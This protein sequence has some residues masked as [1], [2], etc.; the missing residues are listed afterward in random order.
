MT[1]DYKFP[2]QLRE[3]IVNALPEDT[4][5]HGNEPELRFTYLPATHAKALRPESMLVVG[6]RGSGKSF[7]WSALQKPEHRETVGKDIGLNRNTKVST[8]FGERPQPD[9]YPGKD[10]LTRLLVEFEARSI[11]RT[12]VLKQIGGGRLPEEFNSLNRWKDRIGWLKENP[13]PVEQFFYQVDNEL[14]S[15]QTYHLVLFDALD[16]T[17]D[18]WKT[19][20]Q[21]IRGLLQTV[22]DFRSSHRIRLKMFVRPDQIEDPEVAAFPDSSKM[23]SQKTELYWPR[24]ELYGLLWQHLANEATLG[25][26]R[27]GCEKLTSVKWRN[28]EGVWVVPEKLRTDESMQR[29]VFH[30]MT[31][32]WMGRD[33]RRGFPYTWLPNHLGDTRN[34]VSPRSFLAALRHAASEKERSEQPFALHYENIKRGVQEASKIRVREMQEDYPWVQ[35]LFEPLSG[36]SV[37]CHADEIKRI[38]KEHN[39]LNGL[40]HSIA[41]AAVRLPPEHIHVGSEGVLADLASLGLIER[42]S[43]DR[44]NIPD[45]YRVGYGIGRRGGVKPAAR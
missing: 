33:R 39:V 37:P 5:R 42:L 2:H 35:T 11:W 29:R 9:D 1:S 36:I 15:R 3:V 20:N 31:G 25:I 10:T 26:F 22:L 45:V 24:I 27:E 43:A 18:D 14:E 28:T 19:M 40:E 32:P 8:G 30:A 34:Q 21:L 4:S 6:I 17:A 44:I 16:R 38:W 7:W 23:L 41:A 13:E 12:V